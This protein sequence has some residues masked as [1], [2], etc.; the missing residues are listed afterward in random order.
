MPKF[1]LRRLDERDRDSR[2][3]IFWTEGRR[4]KRESTG[5]TDEGA[6]QAYYARWILDRGNE[7]SEVAGA[8]TPVAD[9]WD[10][11]ARRHVA[12]EV[13]STDTARFSWKNLEP[14]F[15][16]LLL[17]QIDQDCVD[18][19]FD[20]RAAGRIGRPSKPPTV[21]RELVALRACLNWCAH[22]KRKIVA[23]A[24]L[25][26]FDLP[27]SGEARDR[28][29]KDAE[30]SRLLAAAEAMRGGSRLSRGERFLRI[31]LETAARKEAI[32]E[33]TWDRVDFETGVIH[34]NVPGRKAT[35]K[36]RADVPISAALRPWLERAYAE[37]T[38]NL[39]MDH[40][41]EVWALVQ[42]I[43]VKAGF[44]GL[45]TP[46]GKNR[47]TGISPHVLRHTAATQMARRGVPL[48]KVSKILG[49]SMLMTERVY[50]KWAP[51]DLQEAVNSISNWKEA[52]E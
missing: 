29:L 9:L 24:L 17:G 25:P 36:R 11:Y 14:H 27:A 21:R 48:Y 50:A 3:Y 42:A 22:P 49:N 44:G 2:F 4:S 30:I 51:G 47:A 12:R 37:R 39:V 18:R 7:A 15:G 41:G 23:P 10:V 32:M 35:K 33:L 16:P 20:K 40:S 46:S 52:A 26:V 5:E 1:T 43:A 19:Y 6:A 31:A 8:A 45:K 38:G 13:A 28:W 34:L